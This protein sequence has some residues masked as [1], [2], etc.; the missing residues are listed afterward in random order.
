MNFEF[1]RGDIVKLSNPLF[2]RL[3][4][5]LFF[6][7]NLFVIGDVDVNMAVVSLKDLSL[8]AA[9]EDILPV[10]I[11]GKEDRDIYYDPVV[12]ASVIPIGGKPQVIS[13]DKSEYYMESLKKSYDKN[14]ETYWDVI[15]RMGLEYVHQIQHQV[16]S[17]RN[18]LKIHR[19]IKDFANRSNVLGRLGRLGKVLTEKE[20]NA[21]EDKTESDGRAIVYI[22]KDIDEGMPI[23]S[24]NG[25]D[26]YDYVLICPQR[27]FAYYCAFFLNSA[28]GRSLL[29]PDKKSCRL[30]GRTSIARIRKLPVYYIEEYA[31]GCEAMQ[32]L[33]EL[34]LLYMKK[35]EAFDNGKVQPVIGFFLSLGDSLVLE[36][37][38]PKLYRH[39]GISMLKPWQKEVELIATFIGK[40]ED[41]LRKRIEIVAVLLDHLMSSDN[42][43]MENL[44]RLRLYLT[45]FMEY[46]NKKVAQGL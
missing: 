1:Q 23:A 2:E 38:V 45:D 16:P 35:E 5:E 4:S 31:S 42:E 15:S 24:V 10:R 26:K 30:K 7:Q 32:S 12:A 39:A 46:A 27:N 28:I 19:H 25:F 41:N 29:L 40:E 33:V 14:H 11:D 44:K 20:Y 3:S 36:M 17:L 43:L 13:R 9:M 22:R 18:D 37:V 34:L 21:K 8:S 6:S